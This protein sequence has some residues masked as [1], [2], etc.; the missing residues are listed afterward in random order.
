MQLGIINRSAN[1]PLLSESY[2]VAHKIVPGQTRSVIVQYTQENDWHK[3]TDVF[4]LTRHTRQLIVEV[5]VDK[6]RYGHQNGEETHV[7]AIKRNVKAQTWT[8]VLRQIHRPKEGFLTQF[9]CIREELE[10]GKQNGHLQQH[11]HTTT[12][13][14]NPRFAVKRHVLLLHFLH[15]VTVLFFYH[16]QLRLEDTHFGRADVWFVNQG[17]QSGFDDDGQ[18]QDNDSHT[19]NHTIQWMKHGDYHISVNPSKNPPSQRNDTL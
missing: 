11:R 14:G 18:Q 6:G 5:R 2:H 16:V 1:R 9:K 13:W 4:H 10:H 19:A 7:I 12:H 8:I 15:V 17:Q 3:V